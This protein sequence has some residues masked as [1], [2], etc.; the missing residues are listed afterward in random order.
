MGTVHIDRN[1]L[2]GLWIFMVAALAF[3]IWLDWNA[4][5]IGII[6]FPLFVLNVVFTSRLLMKKRDTQEGAA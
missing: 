5:S 4:L 1:I 2:I 3:F 6:I